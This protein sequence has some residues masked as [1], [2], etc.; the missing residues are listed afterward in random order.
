MRRFLFLSAILVWFFSGYAYD[1][2]VYDREEKLPLTGATVFSQS[3]VIIGIT[4]KDGSLFKI[5]GKDYP[6]TIKC[7]GFNQA[8]CEKGE[9]EVMLSPAV[10]ELHEVVVTPAERPVM[11]VVCY[12]R[13]YISGATGQ[14]T[15]INFNEH[16]ADFFLAPKKLKGF[17]SRLNPRF[18]ASRLY[19]RE[20]DSKGR[21]SIYRPEFRRDD[22]AWER[23]LIF[24]EADVRLDDIF[25]EGAKVE[26]VAGKSGVKKSSKLTSKFFS[27]QND[28]LASYKE[29]KLSPWL[30][31]ML[32]MTMDFD[33]LQSNWVYNNNGSRVLSPSDLISGTFSISVLGKGRWIKKAFHSDDAV[34][35]YGYYEIYPVEAEYLT[36]DE[37]KEIMENPPRVKFKVSSAATPLSP[38]IQ[39][40]VDKV[41]NA[42]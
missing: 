32:G 26:N 42:R 15:V 12:V 7:L 11:R 14:D 9:S 35:L 17:K 21:D 10:Y 41:R 8:I 5:S 22:V 2:K 24:P 27:T 40:I 4:D 37:A 1:L 36:K 38:A 3:G 16:M 19:A 29:H 13:E 33:E 25:K 23:L 31:K 34:R 30:F 39:R 20:A 18:L 6:L 28:Y